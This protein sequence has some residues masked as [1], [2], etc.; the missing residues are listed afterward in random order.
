MEDSTATAGRMYYPP[1]GSP[2]LGQLVKVYLGLAGSQLETAPVVIAPCL[3]AA[4]NW[5]YILVRKLRTHQGVD[6]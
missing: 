5:V 2:S 1:T 6:Q 4:A 3:K